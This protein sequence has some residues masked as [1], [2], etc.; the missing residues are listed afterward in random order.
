MLRFVLQVAVLEAFAAAEEEHAVEQHKDQIALLSSQLQGALEVLREWKNE[1]PVLVSQ[2]RALAGEVQR[3]RGALRDALVRT[4]QEVLAA[5]AAAEEKVFQKLSGWRESLAKTTIEA[6]QSCCNAT[7]YGTA[8]KCNKSNNSS[9]SICRL[10]QEG[11]G[12]SA[13][14]GLARRHAAAEMAIL[15]L[16]EALS[17]AN[18]RLACYLNR[19]PNTWSRYRRE[20]Q[21]TAQQEVSP[22]AGRSDPSGPEHSHTQLTPVH[23]APQLPCY[24]P[25]ICVLERLL[26][27]LQSFH[28]S[29]TGRG[30]WISQS[31]L[32]LIVVWS[33]MQTPWLGAPRLVH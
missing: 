24:A 13:A 20:Q 21:Q 27:S 18:L 5:E 4:R 11:G 7:G 10:G 9:K 31:F 6:A 29:C 1:R 30:L 2:R 3:L 15:E 8:S 23:A 22:T 16:T 14:Y 28:A 33:H 12:S 25:A 32:P 17:R 26:R 19:T